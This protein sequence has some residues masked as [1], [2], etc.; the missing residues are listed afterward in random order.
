MES[1]NVKD[2]LNIDVSLIGTVLERAAAM[3]PE[4][5]T[6]TEKPDGIGQLGDFIRRAAGAGGMYGLLALKMAGT[7][8]QR[9]LLGLSR[10]ER[11]TERALQ[12][13]FLL[14]TGDT[15]ALP[16]S[17]PSA[18]YLL[19]ALRDAYE[20]ELKNAAAYDAAAGEMPECAL[21]ALYRRLADRERSHAAVLRGIIERTIY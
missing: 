2:D 16:V 5:I 11:D 20:A 10:E 19:R 17:H 18:P 13:E 6:A 21:C 3:A 12:T 1:D 9:E 15:L 14:L 7:K 4:P 8:A